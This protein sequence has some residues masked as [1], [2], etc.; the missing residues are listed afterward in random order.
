MTQE[1]RMSAELRTL[2]VA[3]IGLVIA[4]RSD[5]ARDAMQQQQQQ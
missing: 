2:S 1:L 3:N 5:A 4:L